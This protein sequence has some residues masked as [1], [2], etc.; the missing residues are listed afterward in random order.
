M[1]KVFLIS[2]M[3]PNEQYPGYGSFVKNVVDGLRLRGYE[4]VATALIVGRSE[5]FPEKLWKYMRFYLQILSGYFRKYDFIYVHFP[6]Q[7]LPLLLPLYLIRP[8]KVIVNLHGED[9]LYEHGGISGLLGHMNDF[10]MK[11]ADAVVVPSDY[12][13]GLVLDRIRCAPAKLIV[14]PSGGIDSSCFFPSPHKRDNASL[15]LGYVGRID[16]GKGWSDFIR[17]LLSL[18]DSLRYKATII[19]NGGQVKM[20]RALLKENRLEDVKYIPYVPQNVLSQYY[21][22]FDLLLLFSSRKAESLGLVGI[23]AMA[24]GTPVLGNATGGIPSYL[25]DGYNGFLTETGN[26]EQQVAAVV[27]FYS[28]PEKDKEQ[29]RRHCLLTAS[30][31]FSDKVLD[32]LAEDIALVVKK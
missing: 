21:C 3:W 20:M 11:K 29:M 9:L 24:C 32:A 27:K 6:N 1:K 14:S 16:E 10:F 18:P 17:I 28:L 15:H 23:E 2:N 19:G 31:Y 5:S 25:K 30:R 22:S 8:V 12:F 13:K 7:S 4:F 26:L